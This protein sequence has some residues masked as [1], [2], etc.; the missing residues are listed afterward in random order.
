GAYLDAVARRQA[1]RGGPFTVAAHWDPY[2]WDGWLIA[3]AGG[4]A[5]VQPAELQQSLAAFGI[6]GER[7]GEALRRLLAAPLPQVAVAAR[8]LPALIAEAD[9]ATAE[10]LFAQMAP[11]HRGEKSG[12]PAGLATAYAAPRDEREARLTAL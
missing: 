11:L 12:R 1:G 8:D 5:G 4:L 6:P 3:A 2:Q 7:S 9:A 10:A